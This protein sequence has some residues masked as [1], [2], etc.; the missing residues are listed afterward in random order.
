MAPDE[1]LGDTET[2]GSSQTLRTLLLGQIYQGR[3]DSGLVLGPSRYVLR[4][5]VPFPVSFLCSEQQGNF[6][7]DQKGSFWHFLNNPPFF[8]LTGH[9]CSF[10]KRLKSIESFQKCLKEVF[11]LAEAQ[12]IS[13]LFSSLM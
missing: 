13:Q 6:P 1:T 4:D 10:G 9:C 11:Q 2:W 3:W 12:M 5:K 8:C 7:N